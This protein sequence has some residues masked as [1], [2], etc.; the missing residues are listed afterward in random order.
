MTRTTL[1]ML[2][3]MMGVWTWAFAQPVQRFVW[4]PNPE[5]DIAGYRLYTCPA[6]PCSLRNPDG[7]INPNATL[8]AD[9]VETAYP[10]PTSGS[11][12]AFVTAYDES[13]NQSAESEKLKYPLD[14]TAPGAPGSFRIEAN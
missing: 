10:V 9:T 11:G 14:L 4:D 1:I 3:L 8:L 6:E 7:T 2:I 13:G 12:I 5:P